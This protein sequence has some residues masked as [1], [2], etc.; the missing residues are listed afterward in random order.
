M[1]ITQNIHTEHWTYILE[2]LQALLPKKEI[3]QLFAQEPLTRKRGDHTLVRSDQH[4]LVF[5]TFKGDVL[6]VGK[7]KE[8]AL[9]TFLNKEKKVCQKA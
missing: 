5:N 7:D 3:K 2:Q 9:N 6:Y 4:F 1:N 8:Q